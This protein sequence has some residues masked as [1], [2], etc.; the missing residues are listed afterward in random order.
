MISKV[1][2]GA[3]EAKRGLVKNNPQVG[4]DAI[5]EPNFDNDIPPD[6]LIISWT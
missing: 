6:R 5:D 1:A 2:L 3:T 4:L